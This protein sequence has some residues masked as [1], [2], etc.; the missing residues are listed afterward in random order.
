[1]RITLKICIG[2]N[3]NPVLVSM[4]DRDYGFYSQQISVLIGKTPIFRYYDHQYDVFIL[5]ITL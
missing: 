1:M 4:I 5:H 2:E 3:G